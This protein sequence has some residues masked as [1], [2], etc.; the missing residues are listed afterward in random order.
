MEN[1]IFR[2][3]G[4]V[5][6]K[7]DMEDF[8]GPLEL[9]L[10]LTRKNKIEIKDISISLILEQY[11]TYL[12]SLA[13]MDLEFASEFIAMASYLLY[14]KTKMLLSGEEEVDELADLI[15][16]LED[17]RRRDCYAQIK[18]VTEPLL[19]LYRRG[20]GRIVKP[21]E[22]FTPD[23]TYPFE[24]DANDLIIALA[25][26][27]DK[28]VLTAADEAKP[29]TYPSPIV[30]S[31]TE[32][33]SEILTRVRTRGT[34]KIGFLFNEAQSRTEMVAVFIAVLELC[35]TGELYII[36]CDE[37]LMLCASGPDGRSA[38]EYNADET[39]GEQ[40]NDGMAE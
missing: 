18:S 19:E 11:L 16:S 39:D 15:S 6:S 12:D 38:G 27:V 30:Y 36:G 29:F 35:R 21:P 8:V 7:G 14:I 31:V 28:E 2:L 13:A 5:K 37:E 9:I 1:P 20:S 32:K 17:L 34:M 33:T 40:L 10:Q 22:Y 26:L 25:S 4:I 24:H 23:N 3:Q